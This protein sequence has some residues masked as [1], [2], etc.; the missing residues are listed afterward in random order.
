M[1][2]TPQTTHCVVVEDEVSFSLAQL[3]QASGAEAE[4]LIVLVREGV[5]APSGSGPQDWRFP[6]PSLRRA[7]KALRLAR[8]F[9]LGL[10]GASLVMELLDE[11]DQLRASLRRAGIG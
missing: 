6:G 3:C 7:R 2:Q 10:P 9:E 8:D 1:S 5:L 4:Q 11:I